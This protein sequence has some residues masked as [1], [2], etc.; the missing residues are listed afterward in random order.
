MKKCI[1]LVFL[2][3]PTLLMARQHE[4]PKS[5][6]Y[7]LSNKSDMVTIELPPVDVAKSLEKHQYKD[8]QAKPLRFANPNKVEITPATHGSWRQVPGGEIWQLRFTAENATDMNFGITEFHLPKN[9]ELH[10]LSFADA[11]PFY[12][13]PYTQQ[14]NKSYNELWSAPLPG[15][16]VGLELFVPDGVNKDFSFTLTQVS[17]GFRD[18]FKRYGG[19][20]LNVQRQ[21]A[22]N[23]DV[24]C[25]VGD[26]WRD[27][28]RSVAAYTVGGVDTCTGTLIMD[29]ERTFTPFFLTAFHCGLSSGNAASVVTIW[30]YESANCGDLSGGS[31]LDTVSGAIFR[32]SRQDVDSSLIELAST[33][34]EAYGVHWAGWNAT[35]TVPLGSVGIHHPGVDEKAISFNTDALTTVNSC[36]GG[37]GSSTHWEVDNWEDG[38]TEPG[39][40]GSG[41]WDPDTHQLVGMLSG[42]TASCNSI[43]SDCYGKF[44]EAWDNGGPD[45]QNLKPWLDPNDTGITEIDGSDEAPFAIV[46][47]NA[48]IEV[49]SPD[50]AIYNLNILQNDPGFNEVVTLTTSGLPGSATDSFSNDMVTPP[51]ASVL[52]LSNIGS[53][54][55]GSYTFDVEGNSTSENRS[56]TLQLSVNDGAP[57]ATTLVA[58][59][60][61]E[62]G[63][64]TGVTFSWSG[65]ADANDYLIEV[66]TDAGFGNIVMSELTTETSLASTITLSPDTT[67]YWRVTT[68]NACGVG[69]VSVEQSFTTANEICFVG[70]ASIPDND[71]AGVDVQLNPTDTGMIDSLTVSVASNHTYPG[72]LVFTL[73]HDGTDVTL[74]DR[75]GVPATGF[76]CSQDGVDVL[77]DDNSGVPVETACAASSPGIGGTVSPEQALSN[78]TGMTFSGN[79]TLNANDNA[80]IDTGSITEFCLVPVLAPSDVIFEDGFEQ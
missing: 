69:A 75:P 61:G 62:T 40:S 51:G 80:G 16:D 66:A 54:S 52:T 55:A 26:D 50:D 31:R 21:G 49:C 30:N 13:G 19:P 29:A 34:P 17:T 45:N 28:I 70:S 20:G 43:T 39:S 72:D 71:P 37:G 68:S 36:I 25:P 73:S 27:E 74:M 59:S 35:G 42:G 6:L 7:G 77:F 5:M 14:D 8:F 47:D 53:V 48:S 76:G 60:D 15:G 63:V 2:L 23:N 33:P 1:L 58:P 10:F 22:C 24:V 46:A 18:V 44:S 11:T 56:T 4:P 64:S 79:W 57:S 12:D 78:F 38:T 41:I 9:V 32:A 65:L 67:Y 3:L